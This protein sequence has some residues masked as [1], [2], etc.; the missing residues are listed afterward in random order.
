[1]YLPHGYILNHGSDVVSKITF[2]GTLPSYGLSNYNYV[3]GINIERKGYYIDS[4]KV[5]ITKKDGTGKSYDQTTIYKA[6]DFCDASKK[7]C[8]VTLYANWEYDGHV[9]NP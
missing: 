9:A 3:D 1:M 6:S 5:W 2:G 8:T 7:D 4:T